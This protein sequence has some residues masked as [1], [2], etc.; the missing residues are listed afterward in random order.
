MH[1]HTATNR[2]SKQ[3]GQVT[4]INTMFWESGEES[5]YRV[6]GYLCVL[7]W[8]W[9]K[10]AE[11]SANNN[12]SASYSVEPSSRNW[13][14]VSGWGRKWE[15]HHWQKML[16]MKGETQRVSKVEF[17]SQFRNNATLLAWL[18][19]E[20]VRDNNNQFQSDCIDFMVNLPDRIWL[21]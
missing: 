5:P 18:W 17:G 12:D 20:S 14:S 7:L 15:P 3:C 13:L 9:G 10:I 16:Y 1:E 4:A 6:V 2:Q 11:C 8:F 19:F 21:L